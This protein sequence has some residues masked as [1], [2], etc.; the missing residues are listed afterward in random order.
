MQFN[1]VKA[2][3]QYAHMEREN[4]EREQLYTNQIIIP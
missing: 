3:A 4:M 2:L 1:L